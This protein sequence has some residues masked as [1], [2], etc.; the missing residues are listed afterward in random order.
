MEATKPQ[1]SPTP[2]EQV[3]LDLEK[4]YLM[5]T[6]ARYPI[7]IE[8]GR[9]C[10]VYDI[11]GKRYLDFLAGLAVNALGHAHP[12]IVRAIRDQASKEIHVSN[13]YYHPYQGRLAER[14]AKLTGLDR[15]FLCN[16]GTE[17]VE[18]A[19]K[20]ARAYNA[21]QPDKYH[22]IALDNSFHGRTLGALS[23]TGQ[24]KYRVPFQPLLP[25]VEFARFNDLDDLRSRV[26]DRTAAILV[27]PVQG[28]GG[29]FEL[30]P[31][32]LRGAQELARRHH[33]VLIV[34]E[35]QCG[36]GRTG[37]YFAYQRA[38]ITPD[39]VVMAKP[40]AA[41]LPLGAIAARQEVAEALGAGMHG[42]TFGG[43]P[44]ACRVALEFL[45][46]MEQEN[47]IER[48]NKMG[49]ALRAELVVL[50]GRFPFIK[51]VR[52][53]GLMLAL[54]LEFPARQIVLDALEAGLLINSTHETV[55]RF[56]PPY[57]I[58]EELVDRGIRILKKILSKVTPPPTWPPEA[59]G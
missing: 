35:I 30:S 21:G 32:Y 7:V 36:F 41:G 11:N 49:A 50:Q 20:I 23:A 37:V 19:L 43:G 33:A 51:A 8:R 55:L 52:G 31:E 39:V 6:Y 56:L 18:G 28:E 15:V 54:D 47:M 16:S 57:I 26:N 53:N 27:E 34:D 12:R 4:Q 22:V 5:Q 46:V 45:E 25:G 3:V 58:T 48:I 9:G 1:S 59:A 10:W 40:L 2:Q 14:L 24:A 17:A 13:L 38:G 42:T 44:L 29:I